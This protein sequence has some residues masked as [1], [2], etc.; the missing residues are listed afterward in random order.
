M[1]LGEMGHQTDSGMET[2]NTSEIRI[3]IAIY[4]TDEETKV[5]KGQVTWPKSPFI[6]QIISISSMPHTVPISSGVDI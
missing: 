5:Q 6:Q 1:G 3:I 4:L 2:D